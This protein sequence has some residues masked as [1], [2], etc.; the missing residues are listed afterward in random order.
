MTEIKRYKSPIRIRINDVCCC[1]VS[2]KNNIET[3]E[4]KH[5]GFNKVS[6]TVVVMKLNNNNVNTSEEDCVDI[7]HVNHFAVLCVDSSEDEG[8]SLDFDT[9]TDPD[10]SCTVRGFQG[11]ESVGMHS[12]LGKKLSNFVKKS[13]VNVSECQSFVKSS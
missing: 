5:V 9:V 3:S 7:T 8:D 1:S 2:S 11:G 10:A 4:Q 6:R 12:K 13:P